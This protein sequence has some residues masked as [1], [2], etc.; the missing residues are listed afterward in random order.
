MDQ[1]KN[2]LF[3]EVLLEVLYRLELQKK[4]QN[5][6]EK[7][8]DKKSTQSLSLKSFYESL[9]GLYKEIDT[10]KKWIEEE[11]NQ[12]DKFWA[13]SKDFKTI[14]WVVI[15]KDKKKTVGIKENYS[16]ENGLITKLTNL[17]FVRISVDKIKTLL[18]NRG[19]SF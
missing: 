3:E 7:L 6:L 1:E 2:K 16:I 13:R 19:D 18:E 15:W 14:Y 8:E 9:E 4:K 12:A 10:R 5:I 17:D 11:L